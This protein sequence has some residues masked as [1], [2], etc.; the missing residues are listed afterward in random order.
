MMF[1]H[2]L[3]V[4]HQGIEDDTNQTTDGECQEGQALLQCVKAMLTLE[5]NGQSFEKQVWSTLQ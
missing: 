2:V 4:D 5:D 3:F 1:F